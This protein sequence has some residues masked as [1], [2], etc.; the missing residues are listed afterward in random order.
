MICLVSGTKRQAQG[1][2]AAGGEG[3]VVLDATAVGLGD[4]LG[5][6]ESQDRRSTP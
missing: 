2:G 6:A 1:E 4:G 5:D 3:A